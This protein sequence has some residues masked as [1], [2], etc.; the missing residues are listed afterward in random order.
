MS[1]RKCRYNLRFASPELWKGLS[2][3]CPTQTHFVKYNIGYE[4]IKS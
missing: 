1:G 2:G 3:N 4:M